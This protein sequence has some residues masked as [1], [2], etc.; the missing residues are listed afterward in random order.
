MP[1]AISPV[2][3]SNKELIELGYT[4]VLPGILEDPD[5]YSYFADGGVSN[6]WGLGLLM[7][8]TLF[9]R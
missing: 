3:M 8:L 2:K 9:K 4:D 7:K 6:T 5:G 1:F